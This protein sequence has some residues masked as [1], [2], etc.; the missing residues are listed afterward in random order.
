LLALAVRRT[1]IG[2]LVFVFTNYVYTF[3]IYSAFESELADVIPVIHTQI[4][5]CRIVGRISAG[6]FCEIT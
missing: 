2:L 6:K 5:G 4:N 1:S 3:S